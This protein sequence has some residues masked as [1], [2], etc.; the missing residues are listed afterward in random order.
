MGLSEMTL[1]ELWQLFPIV[2]T[3]HSPAWAAQY[4]R[5]EAR[6]KTAL[7][8]DALR[9]HHIGS[10]AVRGIAAKPI[11][12]ILLEAPPSASFPRL[13]ADIEAAG[14][15]CMSRS[16]TRISFNRGYTERGFGDEVFHLHLHRYGDH[17]EIFFR[18]YLNAFPDVAKSYEKLKLSLWKQYEHDRDGYTAAKGEF[19]REITQ[20]AE[21]YFAARKE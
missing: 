3:E 12:D 7:K 15:F 14:Y 5:E 4:A 16:E 20:R 19:V 18:D 1:G 2:L 17:R 11:V 10:T 13:K 8:N 9:F 21:T 6:L